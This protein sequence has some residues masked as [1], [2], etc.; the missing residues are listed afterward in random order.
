MFLANNLPLL[1]M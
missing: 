1:E